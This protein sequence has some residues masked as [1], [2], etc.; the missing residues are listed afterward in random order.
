METVTTM[1]KVTTTKIKEIIHI[2][3]EINKW[4]MMVLWTPSNLMINFSFIWLVLI[5]KEVSQ[6]T[7]IG[8]REKGEIFQYS[9]NHMMSY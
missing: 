3:I 6:D 4:S 1:A 2:G 7:K 9:V 8:Q 5:N